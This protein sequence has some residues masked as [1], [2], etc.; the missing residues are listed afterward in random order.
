MLSMGHPLL[1]L[2]APTGMRQAALTDIILARGSR[3]GQTTKGEYM[4][5][6]GSF[7]AMVLT[8]EDDETR[9]EVKELTLDD[10]PEGDILVGIDYWSLNSKD[11]MAVT[12]AGPIVRSWPMLRD[13]L[14]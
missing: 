9:H 8:Q 13:S 7:K 12:G 2:E 6:E 14:W 5:Q 4:S 3:L 1:G 10:L 11:A